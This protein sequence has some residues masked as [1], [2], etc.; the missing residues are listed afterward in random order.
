[1]FFVMFKYCLQIYVNLV[2]V[3]STYLY[4]LFPFQL[5]LNDSVLCLI[6]TPSSLCSPT[7]GDANPNDSPGIG[8]LSST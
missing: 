8:I 3:L 5:P 4:L 2:D 7:N 1:M 6:H